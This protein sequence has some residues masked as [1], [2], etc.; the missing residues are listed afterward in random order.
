MLHRLRNAAKRWPRLCLG[1]VLLTF[2]SQALAATLD[3]CLDAG[4][5]AHIA[6]G[7]SPCHGEAGGAGHHSGAPAP[8][9]APLSHGGDAGSTPHRTLHVAASSDG[10]STLASAM[11]PAPIAATWQFLSR[12]Q[13][14]ATSGSG[15]AL[16][17]RPATLPDARRPAVSGAIPGESSR[18]LI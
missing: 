12:V 11:V 1:L 14:L 6:N 2:T 16:R 5:S 7:L 3:W 15:D 18:L 10:S 8:S 13:W 17:A 4:E 9:T